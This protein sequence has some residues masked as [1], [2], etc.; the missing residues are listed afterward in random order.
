MQRFAGAATAESPGLTPLTGQYSRPG[1]TWVCYP[2]ANP[3]A[4]FLTQRDQSSGAQHCVRLHD[5]ELAAK[6]EYYTAKTISIIETLPIPP[7]P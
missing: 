2:F 1:E 4:F 6:L 7:V 3:D 5:L